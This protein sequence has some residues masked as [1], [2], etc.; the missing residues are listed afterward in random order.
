MLHCALFNTVNDNAT[1]AT[2]LSDDEYAR[3]ARAQNRIRSTRARERR[4]GAGKISLTVWVA[5]STKAALVACAEAE[6]VSINEVADRLLTAG[7]SDSKKLSTGPECAAE[8]Y[9]QDN[10]PVDKSA[11]RDA[12][13]IALHST[14]ASLARISGML[15]TRGILTGTGCPV[16]VNTINGVLKAN[17]LKANG[18][19]KGIHLIESN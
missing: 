16:S 13:I 14:G 10:A 5:E 15:A 9:P 18:E 11:D 19:L 8:S 6:G 17:G 3:R 1:M 12:T 4:Y 7:L 2:K